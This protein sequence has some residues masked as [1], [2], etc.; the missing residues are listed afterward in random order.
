MAFR[1]I[2]LAVDCETDQEQQLVQN[3]A[4]EISETFRVSAKDLIGFYPILRQHKSLLYTAI[5]TVA[6]EGKKGIFR[7]VPLL[8]KQL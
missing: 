3:M 6:K 7:L 8:M 2:V 4:Q 1:K 5:K